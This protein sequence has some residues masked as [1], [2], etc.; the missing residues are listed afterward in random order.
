MI[1]WQVEDGI[2]RLTLDRPDSLNSM[3]VDGFAAFAERMDEAAHSPDVR[4]VVVTGAGRA[5]SAGA[6][7]DP[8][9]LGDPALVPRANRCIL[10]L[11]SCPKP[12]IAAVRGAAAGIGCSIALACDL[13]YAARS[14]YLLLAFARVGLMPDGG[15]TLFV[16]RTV[17]MARAAQMCLL[18]DRVDA[19][20]AERWGLINEV[21]EDDE[22]DRR[23]DEI[24]TRLA[25]GPAQAFAATKRA[26]NQSAYAGLAE[27]LELELAQQQALLASDDL[28]EGL[29]AFRER[30]EPRLG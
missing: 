7:L 24:A 20:T 25:R 13:I 6:D 4:V 30:R 27:Q 26:L 18:A 19:E 9:T 14:S 8:A 21:T 3:T 1:G 29:A 2:G 15:S 23:V 22:L 10:A 17:G 12:V 11:R 16:P 28:K 5:F